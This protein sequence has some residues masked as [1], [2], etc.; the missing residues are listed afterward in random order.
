MHNS[1]EL[2]IDS[3]ELAELI[4]TLGRIGA[5]PSGGLFRPVYGEAWQ[6]AVAQLD[7]WAQTRGLETRQDALGNLYARLAGSVEHGAIVTGSHIDTVKS[8]GKF[9]GALGVIGGLLALAQL[10]SRFGAPVHPIELVVFCEEE[11]SRFHA[12]FLGSRAITGQLQPEELEHITDSD[13]VSIATAMA[14]I[15]LDPTQVQNARRDDVQ[16]FIE[17]HIEQGRVLQDHAQD[18]GIVH[19]ITGIQ[20]LELTVTGRVDHA[21]TT[22]MDLR[23]DPGLAAAEMMLS[24]ARAAQLAGPPAV[25]TIGQFNLTPGAINIVPGTAHF[26]L[27][28]RHPDAARLHQLVRSFELESFD[29]AERRQ[30]ALSVNRLVE[31]APAPMDPRLIAVLRTAAE[32]CGLDARDMVSGAGH[33]AQIMARSFPSAMIFV[34]SRDGRSHCPEELTTGKDALR[35]IEML[36]ETLRALAYSPAP[37]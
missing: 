37:R 9:D 7:Q 28:A 27:D 26:T 13:G 36:A 14:R 25:A 16:A 12:N 1:L 29:I 31:V 15:G 17:L 6:E 18:I 23:R 19:T 11:G 4:E 2:S 3:E 24:A 20:H 21:G 10:K 33:D 34:P 35:G 22:P 5:L 8:G 30:V 32:T